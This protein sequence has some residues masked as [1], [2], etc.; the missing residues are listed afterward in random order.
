MGPAVG[1]FAGG[2]LLRIYD[3]FDRV[4][5]YYYKVYLLIYKGIRKPLKDNLDPRWV[6]AWWIGFVISAISALLGLNNIT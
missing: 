6:G 4:T 3:D 2:F 5:K 1:L